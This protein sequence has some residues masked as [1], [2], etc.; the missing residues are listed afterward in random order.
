MFF[1]LEVGSR[2]VRVRVRGVTANPDGMWTTQQARNLLMDLAER[3]EEFTF[4]IRDRAGQ[5]TAFFDMVLAAAGITVLKTPTRSPRANAFAE[6]FVGTA[7]REVT[8]R[9]L[10]FGR[11]HLHRIL[12]EYAAHYNR[13]R[14]HRSLALRPPRPDRRVADLTHERIK[15]RPILG[16]LITEYERVA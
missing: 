6:R 4:L 7:R 5:S 14:P 16:G 2:Y 1:V 3:A 9:I 10:I 15:R 13:R 11:T 12:D 8:D